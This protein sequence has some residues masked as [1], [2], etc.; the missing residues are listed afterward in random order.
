M[1]PNLIQNNMKKRNLY[2]AAAFFIAL[3][4]FTLLNSVQANAQKFAYVNSQYILDNMPE[5]QAAQK[6]L[7]GI[8]QRWQAEIDTKISELSRKRAE[9]EAEKVLLTEDMRLKREEELGVAQNAL[10][11]LQRKRFGPKGD[12]IQKQGELI[13]PIQDKVYQTIQTVAETKNYGMIFDK[14]GT[15]TIMYGNDR[16]DISDQVLREMGI[17]PGKEEV[18][19]DPNDGMQGDGVI[20][21]TRQ[22]AKDVI[23]KP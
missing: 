4:A 3:A 20:E 15:T 10:L 6:Q 5:Y 2:K 21:Q 19:D 18:E 1:Y 7:D 16:F 8:S 17:E 11:E 14:A 12:L 22:E 13:K 9:Y 23:K